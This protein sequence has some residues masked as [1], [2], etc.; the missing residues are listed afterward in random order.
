MSFTATYPFPTHQ[1]DLGQ[2]RII[3]YMDEGNGPKTIL[4][5]HGLANYA[6][7][8][9][10]NIAALS[11]NYRVLAIDLPGNGLS[12]YPGAEIFS[13]RFLAHCIIDFIGQMGLRDVCLCG[14][15][16]GGQI[17]ITA[18]LEA[19]LCA[20]KLAL[21]A[22]AGLEQFSMTEKMM[23]KQGMNFMGWLASDEQQLREALRSSFY[24]TGPTAEKIG[25]E[26]T[27]LMQL[28]QK[29]GA[30]KKMVHQCIAAMVDEPVADRLSQIK[31]PVMIIFGEHDALIP[32]RL[33]PHGTTRQLAESAGKKFP[34]ARVFM[35]NEA[36]HFVQWE[37]A[38]TVN[39]LIR[40]FMEQPT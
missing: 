10:Q 34:N 18:L 20:E 21:I 3:S 31:Q 1:I 6:P 8:W 22:P 27:R 12:T 23:V 5:I 24:K 17:A 19:P 30:Y 39:D 37:K 13:M 11:K 15:S 2:Q 14:H 9:T 38:K 26:L 25:N 40:K 16:M 29:N 33:F 28:H 35:I 32:N 4:F 7:V 36:G